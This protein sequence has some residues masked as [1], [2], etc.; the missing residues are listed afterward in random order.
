MPKLFKITNSKDINFNDKKIKNIDFLYE[1]KG[2]SYKIR[3]TEHFKTF[4]CASGSCDLHIEKG[5][6]VEQVR[7]DNISQK[8]ETEKD[9]AVE[10]K[11][12]TTDTKIVVDYFEDINR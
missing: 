1:L 12:Y 9:T 2:E 11:N 5:G 7:L 3:D 10:I 6:I 4:I 8:V